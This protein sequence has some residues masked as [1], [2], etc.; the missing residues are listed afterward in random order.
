MGK[1]TSS[2]ATFF[3]N[4]EIL[5]NTTT[6]NM[7]SMAAVQNDTTSGELLEEGLP[8]EGVTTGFHVY[9]RPYT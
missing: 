8:E 9:P 5:Q 1:C 3:R 6:V 4:D 2:R 7:Q